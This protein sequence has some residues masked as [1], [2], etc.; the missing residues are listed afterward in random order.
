MDV[1]ARCI[2]CRRPVPL[3]TDPDDPT[4][5][6]CG[7]DPCREVAVERHDELER[8][9]ARTK[10]AVEPGGRHRAED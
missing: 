5:R 2:G 6:T 4:P 1:R 3:S 10:P 7:R 9:E 8:L